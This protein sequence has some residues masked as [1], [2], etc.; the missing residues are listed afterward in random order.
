VSKLFALS[1]TTAI[2]A[3]ISPYQ[4]DR[5]IARKLHDQAGLPFI[6]VFVDASLEEVEKRDP[7]GLY[8]KARAGEI[9]GVCT[10]PRTGYS[11]LT[12]Y[13]VVLAADF[14]GISAPYEAPSSPEIHIKTDS[15][16]IED[17]VKQMV[18]YLQEKKYI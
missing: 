2:T 9:K 14:T 12:L 11:E 17:G 16:S 6:E 7:K 10:S 1:A 4:A 15:S 18:A 3:F 5:D 13:A 8:K